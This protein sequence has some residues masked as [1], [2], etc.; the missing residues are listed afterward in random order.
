MTKVF[1]SIAASLDGYLGARDGDLSWLNDAMAYGEDYGFA[2]TIERT[3]VYIMGANTHRDT[4]GMS[5]GDTTPTYVVTHQDSL[6]TSS[7]HVVPYR[8]DPRTL[9]AEAKRKTDKDVYL[10]GGGNL[11]TQFIELDLLD[12][13]ILGIVPVLLGDGVPLFGALTARKKLTLVSCKHYPSGI[14]LS[15]YKRSC[16]RV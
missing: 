10:F 7:K 15:R 6:Q 9:V 13:L 8:G 16:T 14:V 3:G 5:G 11:L 4:A 1:C 2:E 12:E